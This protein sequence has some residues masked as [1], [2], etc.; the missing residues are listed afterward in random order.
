MPTFTST[1]EVYAYIEQIKSQ[2]RKSSKDT[3]TMSYMQHLDA[4]AFQIARMSSYHSINSTYRNLI[5]GLA[6][7]DPYSYGVARCSLCS[8]TF[9]TDSRD[10]VKEHRRVHRNLDALAVD[11]GIVPDNHQE[12]ER[13]KSI[14]WSE[15]TGENSEAEMARWEVIAKAWFD[16]S[17]FSAARAGY[18]KKHPSLDRFVA[19]L[20]DDGIHPRCNCIGLLKAKYGSVKGPVS[21]KSSYW[22]PGS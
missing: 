21:I 3:P 20:V 19:M 17:V 4:A 15:M 22:R 9:S 14:A 2:A 11:R 13:K 18:S 8:M 1:S 5:D 7:A 6:E 10:D 12:R 16:R